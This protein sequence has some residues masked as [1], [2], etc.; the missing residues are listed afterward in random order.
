M[1]PNENLSRTAKQDESG[2][3]EDEPKESEECK[4]DVAD[5]LKERVGRRADCHHPGAAVLVTTVR[6]DAFTIRRIP[7]GM[8]I[9]PSAMRNCNA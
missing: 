6:R 7:S 4:G 3:A 8:R 5:P 2:N 9:T 1:I